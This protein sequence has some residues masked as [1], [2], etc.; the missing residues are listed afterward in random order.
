[1]GIISKNAVEAI[2]TAK[3]ELLED[4]RQNM[5]ENVLEKLFGG[6][7]GLIFFDHLLKSRRARK[8]PVVHLHHIYIHR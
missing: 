6:A 8:Y 1:M 4:L 3:N 7:M 2:K 5:P